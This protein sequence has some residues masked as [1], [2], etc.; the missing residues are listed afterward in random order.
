MRLLC[1][2]C[3]VLYLVFYLVC[4]VLLSIIAYKMTFD[5]VMTKFLFFQTLEYTMDNKI[6]MVEY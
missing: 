3:F 1:S 2:F 6:S 4:P 5:R